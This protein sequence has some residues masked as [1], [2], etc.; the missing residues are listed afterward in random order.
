MIWN[1]SAKIELTIVS[2]GRL[3]RGAD[4]KPW[5]L[6]RN[7]STTR[8]QHLEARASL[9]PSPPSPSH[10]L[11]QPLRFLPSQIPPNPK[12]SSE[13]TALAEPLSSSQIPLPQNSP[14]DWPGRWSDPARVPKPA[15]E[16]QWLAEYPHQGADKRPRKRARLAWD[17]A[18][19]LFQPPKVWFS[20][21]SPHRLATS[22]GVWLDLG[23]V[24]ARFGVGW[25]DQ[26]L[27]L[28][29]LG[30]YSFAVADHHR[31]LSS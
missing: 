26:G 9:H 22:R 16:A 3:S 20:P 17:V 25:L 7:A 27:Q 10:L 13:S 28:V 30:L 11:L 4:T 15:M 31:S 1:N 8:P 23:A 19:T 29:E 12:S 21:R 2:W 5:F 6:G 24:F 14:P 18:P